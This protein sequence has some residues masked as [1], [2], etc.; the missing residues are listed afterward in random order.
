MKKRY[1]LILPICILLIVFLFVF[2]Y[3]SWI[4]K[5][6]EEINEKN[7]ITTPYKRS[8]EVEKKIMNFT[9]S[10][11]E[12]E[13]LELA[14]NEFVGLI[15]EVLNTYSVKEIYVYPNT[16]IW[17]I[18]AKIRVLNF[19]VWVSI[20][21]NKDNMQ[22]AQLYVTKVYIGPYSIGQYFN[23]Q[24]SINVGIADALLTVNENG[25][26]GRYFENIELLKDVVVVKGSRY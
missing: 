2:R 7:L 23:I 18:Y 22:T 20:D 13:Y 19:P 1:L 21:L 17:S 8:E 12:T 11:K 5:F 26:S 14:P 15:L 4:S 6:K 3:Y 9:L 10:E 25:F 24:E 16:G